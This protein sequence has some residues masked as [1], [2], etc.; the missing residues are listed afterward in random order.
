MKENKDI[1]KELESISPFLAN[2]KKKES[3]KVPAHYFEQLADDV[4][5]EAKR[6]AFEADKSS[7][8]DSVLVLLWNHLTSLFQPKYAVRLASFAVLVVAGFLT[9]QYFSN[10]TVNTLDTFAEVTVEDVEEY[11]AGNIEDFEG[12]WV[13]DIVSADDIELSNQEEEE[14]IDPYLEEIIDQLDDQELQEL[15]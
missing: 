14:E 4:I 6:E 8:K 15:L 3:F 7:T 9:W 11:I 1:Q 2:M 12:A 5:R 13:E 10:A